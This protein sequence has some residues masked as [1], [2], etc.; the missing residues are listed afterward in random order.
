[1]SYNAEK[2]RAAIYLALASI[3]AGRVISYGQLAA[4]AGLPG[5]A[6]LVGNLLR[7]LPAGT[8]LPWHRVV[9]AQRKISLPAD[10]VG[11]NEQLQRLRS[12]GVEIINGKIKSA[13]LW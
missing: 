1:M 8:Q 3:P 6:R 7:N 2:N 9:N 11:F 4:L 13:Y 12:E 10:S 5:A